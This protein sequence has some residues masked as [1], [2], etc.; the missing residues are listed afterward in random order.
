MSYSKFTVCIALIFGLQG[1]VG[2]QVKA[3]GKWHFPDSVK[4]L[5]LNY[6]QNLVANYKSLVERNREWLDENF[7]ADKSNYFQITE[8]I[9]KSIAEYELSWDRLG[10]V[11]IVYGVRR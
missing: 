1:S 9:K 4:N 7:K 11:S 5:C 6:E 10:C 3:D 2:A 8:S